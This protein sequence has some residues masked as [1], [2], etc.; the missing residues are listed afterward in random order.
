MRSGQ[1]TVAARPYP[2]LLFLVPLR[3]AGRLH[4]ALRRLRR[5][6]Q[7]PSG[8]IC[9][10]PGGNE[11]RRFSPTRAP[12]P[13]RRGIWRTPPLRMGPHSRGLEKRGIRAPPARRGL[14]PVEVELGRFVRSQQRGNQVQAGIQ[15]GF[16]LVLKPIAASG[17]W[18]D[19]QTAP[20]RTWNPVDLGLHAIHTLK[21]I[22][23]LRGRKSDP[24][25]RR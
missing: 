8:T 17:S 3:C 25:G 6:K 10:F 15:P 23:V 22:R 14:F 24:S 1:P 11:C 5:A 16:H 13:D 18:N 2:A 9:R 4:P 19:S 12:T 21:M 7:R 20:P